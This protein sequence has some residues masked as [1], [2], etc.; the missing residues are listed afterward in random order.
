MIILT[1]SVASVADHIYKNYLSDKDYKT[2]LFID[3]ASE[4]E[5]GKEAGDD[6]WLQADLQSL[7]AQGYEVDRWS[8][9][10][11]SKEEIESKIDE[12]DVLYMCGGNTIYLLQQLKKTNSFD[13]IKEKVLAGKPY[14]GT[15]A[16][17]IIACAKIPHYLED[18]EG[19]VLD[20]YTGFEFTNMLFVPHWG[21]PH[22]KE[23][24]LE[25]RIKKAYDPTE[26]PF[27]LMSDYCYVTV[28]DGDITVV[29]TKA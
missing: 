8:I 20:D 19:I 21:S 23:M 14:I 13:L 16:G 11:K 3:T 4:P 9:T 28:Q 27:L 25:D 12:Y 24:Y 29:N 7:Q 5:I 1:S 6:D 18:S 22:F 15:S 26:P 17:S 2:V 10:D